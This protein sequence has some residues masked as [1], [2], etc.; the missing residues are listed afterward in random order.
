M[1]DG[2]VSIRTDGP[3]TLFD[4]DSPGAFAEA[5]GSQ[6]VGVKGDVAWV[7]L[8]G[9]DVHPVYRGWAVIQPDGAGDGHARFVSPEVLAE[10]LART[11]V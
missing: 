2:R 11:A 3:Y 1:P 6:L 10:G 7:R 4:P 9:G 5:T 8:E